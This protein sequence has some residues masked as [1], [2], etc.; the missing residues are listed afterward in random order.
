MASSSIEILLK[1]ILLNS[2]TKASISSLAFEVVS[3]SSLS[4]ALETI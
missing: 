2:L 4:L 1:A 3:L